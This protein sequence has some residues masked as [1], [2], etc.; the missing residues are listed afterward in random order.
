MKIE[1]LVT[2]GSLGKNLDKRGFFTCN[3]VLDLPQ[4]YIS[5]KEVFLIFKDHR[6][7][8]VDVEFS[9]ENQLKLK[10]L[11]Q[12]LISD[13]VDSR[14][15][16]IA[17]SQEDVDE[18]RIEQGLIPVSKL[19]IIFEENKIGTLTEIFDNN[20]HEILVVQLLN[21]KE[22]MIPYVERFVIGTTED[23]II[24]KNIEDLLKL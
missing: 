13:I 8:F 10:I 14:G 11:D 23:R 21:G 19:D 24:V 12:D 5:I 1:E 4:D 3:K 18:L 7:R 20:A 2:V 15:A 16:K 6:V 9:V 22:I 17:L